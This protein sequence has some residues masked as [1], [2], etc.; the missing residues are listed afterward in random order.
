MT[1][2][3]PNFELI[4]IIL[5]DELKYE[6]TI[7]EINRIAKAT[8]KIKCFEYSNENITS[9]RAQLVY[10]WIMSLANSGLSLNE[11]IE[12][13]IY[14]IKQFELSKKTKDK[15]FKEL[16]I[17]QEKN[18]KKNPLNIK[19]NL[20]HLRKINM[21]PMLVEIL[22]KRLIEIEKCIN[23]G[24]YLSSI[25][26]MGSFLEGLLLAITSL[27]PKKANQAKTAPKNKNG[28]I[29]K[30]HEWKLQDFI[31]VCHECGWIEVD[32]KDFSILLRDYRNMIHPYHQL[33]KGIYPDLD[34]AK[35][36]YEVLNAVINDLGSKYI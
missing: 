10:D 22:E 32:V 19:L 24:A 1:N 6:S 27:D 16:G 36:C 33:R 8:L 21:E 35:I 25:I 18:T 13:C 17:S 34:T 11:K 4:A 26:M 3:T 7:K 31:S 30:F 23:S 20:G 2:K 14:F 5:G 29:K 9:D 12:R 15:I 28:K